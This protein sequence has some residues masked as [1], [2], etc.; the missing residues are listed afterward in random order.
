[1]PVIED[2]QT[3]QGTIKCW[4]IT[5][6]TGD[7]EMQCKS[8]SIVVHND[9]TL[10]ARYQQSMVTRLLHAELFPDTILSYL[11]TGK[12]V[13][14]NEK[15]ISISHSGDIV[16]MMRSQYACGVDIEKIHERVG[17]VRHKFLNDEEL[18]L[19]IHSSKEILTQ[20]WTA[21]EAMFKVHGTDTIFMRNNIFVKLHSPVLAEARLTDGDLVIERN[22]RYYVNGDMMLAW[23]ETNDEA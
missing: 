19:N 18:A 7:L 8:K 14:D 11:P 22:I 6:N 17:K 15:F 13:V 9:F 2:I 10:E 23:T 16:V 1:M 4:K 5:E 3:K 21:K 20:Y 12:P